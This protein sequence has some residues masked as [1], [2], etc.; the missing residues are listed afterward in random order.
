MENKIYLFVQEVNQEELELLMLH[1]GGF[2]SRG[3]KKVNFQHPDVFLEH[4]IEKY[5]S[6]KPTIAI[7]TRGAGSTYSLYLK[8]QG[9]E[10][11]QV[12][13]AVLGTSHFQDKYSQ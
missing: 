9:Y 1:K 13:H 8:G 12:S 5:Y 3:F 10:V 4:L 2:T 11:E 7:S 6:E